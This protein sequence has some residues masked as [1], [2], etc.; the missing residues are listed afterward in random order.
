MPSDSLSKVAVDVFPYLQSVMRM[1]TTLLSTDISVSKRGL[2]S[3]LIK[4]YVLRYDFFSYCS[5]K[6][7]QKQITLQMSAHTFASEHL[8]PVEHTI[9]NSYCII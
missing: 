4:L 6:E 3:N 8:T 7:V 5:I 9:F 2:F 1:N